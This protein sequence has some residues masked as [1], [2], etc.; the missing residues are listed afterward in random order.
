MLVEAELASEGMETPLT[1]I[2][3]KA[4]SILHREETVAQVRQTAFL[5]LLSHTLGADLDEELQ[6]PTPLT[7]SQGAMQVLRVVVKLLTGVVVVP[8]AHLVTAES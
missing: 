2:A 1:F 5:D 3:T 8:M 7:E 4:D 6:G